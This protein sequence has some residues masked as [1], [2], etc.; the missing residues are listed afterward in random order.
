ME[1]L[2]L[3]HEPGAPAALLED[4]AREREHSL[5]TLR[6]PELRRWPAPGEAEVVVSLGSERSVHAS[7]DGWIAREIE[8]LRAAHDAEVPVLGICFGAQA[9]AKALGGGVARA[10]QFEPEW[11]MLETKDP[12]LIPPGPWLRWHED[13]FGVPPNAREIVRAG[14]VP[15]AFSSGASVGIQFHPEVGVE[16]VNAWI[17]DS[18]STLLEHEIDE[19]ELRRHIE[20]AASGALER[21][22]DL[23]DRIA[24]LWERRGGHGRGA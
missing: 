24:R 8:F 23:F 2:V 7:Q 19:R 16:V 1:V 17:E 11:T 22:E 6:V 20:L 18:R 12:E 3:E 13:V 21:A 15:L 4:W 10:R 14:E 9:L 5:R